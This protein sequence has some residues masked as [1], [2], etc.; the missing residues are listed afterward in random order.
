MTLCHVLIIFGA[1][2]SQV[3]PKNQFVVKTHILRSE[4]GIVVSH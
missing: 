4:T 1:S 3:M 2:C